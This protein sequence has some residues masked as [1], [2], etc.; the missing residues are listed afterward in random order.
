M[1]E[2]SKSERLVFFGCSR[3]KVRANE[4]R[5]GHMANGFEPSFR[6]FFDCISFRT[7]ACGG[8]VENTAFARL[9]AGLKTAFFRVVGAGKFMQAGLQIEAGRPLTRP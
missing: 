2:F 5:A 3:E 7:T 1:A 8:A 9:A 4:K 6:G